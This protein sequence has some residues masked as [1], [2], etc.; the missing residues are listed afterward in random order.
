MHMAKYQDQA[1]NGEI[2]EILKQC[3]FDKR[4]ITIHKSELPVVGELYASGS[5]KLCI[6]TGFKAP[7]SLKPAVDKSKSP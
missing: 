3:N 4:L 7:N 5:W 1:H 2:Q 6:I